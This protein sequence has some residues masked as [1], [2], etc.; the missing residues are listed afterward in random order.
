MT[1]KNKQ[2]QQQEQVQVQVQSQIQGTFLCATPEGQD[3][4]ESHATAKA[5]EEADSQRE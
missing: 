4:G 3:D 2:R 5:K 1:A